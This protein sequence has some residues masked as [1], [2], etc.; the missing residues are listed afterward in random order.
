MEGSGVIEVIACDAERAMF[1][2]WTAWSA[3]PRWMWDEEEGREGT[4]RRRQVDGGVRRKEEKK[5]RDGGQVVAIAPHLEAHS[6]RIYRGR[7]Q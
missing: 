5:R 2:W 4:V 1:G 6:R 7:C 3:V